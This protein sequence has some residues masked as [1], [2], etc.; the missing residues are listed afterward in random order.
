MTGNIHVFNLNTMRM[1]NNKQ[2]SA[3]ERIS[4]FNMSFKGDKFIIEVLTWKGA[5]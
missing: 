2:Y 1:E 3:H 4:S 5:I